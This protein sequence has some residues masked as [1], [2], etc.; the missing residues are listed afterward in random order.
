MTQGFKVSEDVFIAPALLP[1]ESV[2]ADDIQYVWREVVP[3]SVVHLDYVFFAQRCIED[4]DRPPPVAGEAQP[5]YVSYADTGGNP[6][7]SLGCQ[8]DAPPCVPASAWHPAY[9]TT[10]QP[11]H[12][13]T[14]HAPSAVPDVPCLLCTWTSTCGRVTPN[15]TRS[16]R[17]SSPPQSNY[18]AAAVSHPP[19]SCT[20]PPEHRR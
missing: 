20:G 5:V 10:L 2:M 18:D 15:G 1:V 13:A 16:S 3:E 8:T 11:W 9:D 4:A 19:G 12:P 7:R 14:P 6:S 17:S